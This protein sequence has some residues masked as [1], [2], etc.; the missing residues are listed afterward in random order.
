MLSAHLELAD[1]LEGHNRDVKKR[2]GFKGQ[3]WRRENT[4][5]ARQGHAEL[6]GDQSRVRLIRE[7]GWHFGGRAW[8]RLHLEA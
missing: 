5:G 2:F 8:A 1:E 7:R 6:S 4:A 3:L